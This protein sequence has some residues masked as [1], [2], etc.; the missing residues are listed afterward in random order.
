MTVKIVHVFQFSA[1]VAQ[2]AAQVLAPCSGPRHPL[3]SGHRRSHS[4]S[5]PIVRSTLR[6]GARRPTE[7]VGEVSSPQPS[8]RRPVSAG[9]LK[10]ENRRI[11]TSDGED[12]RMRASEERIPY[13]GTPFGGSAVMGS[14]VASG[15]N[16]VE[17]R[18]GSE[19]PWLC[20]PGFHRVCLCREEWCPAELSR[21]MGAVKLG[22]SGR[23]LFG[24][25]GGRSGYQLAGSSWLDALGI[26]K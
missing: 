2:K 4:R 17:R 8:A 20:D 1:P 12:R 13:A 19:D 14:F 16:T 7:P 5:A 15:G 10:R 18:G 25:C 23:R 21:D 3:G 11:A 22:A 6:A 26:K 24:C 9:A